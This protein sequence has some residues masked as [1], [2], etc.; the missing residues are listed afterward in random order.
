VSPD[1]NAF[2]ALVDPKPYV[3]WA[4]YIPKRGFTIVNEYNAR[5][6]GSLFYFYNAQPSKQHVNLEILMKQEPLE[7]GGRRAITA[8]YFVAQEHPVHM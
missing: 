8:R 5:E 1:L 2:G 3:R 7:A 6:P 4:A